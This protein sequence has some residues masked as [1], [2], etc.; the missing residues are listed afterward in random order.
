MAVSPLRKPRIN[1]DVDPE[2]RQTTDETVEPDIYVRQ[3]THTPSAPPSDSTAGLFIAAL[4][5][6][7]GFIIALYFGT[8]SDT[9]A[10]SVTQNTTQTAPESTLPAT[11]PAATTKPAEPAA[12]AQPDTTTQQPSES[13]QQGT[14]GNGNTT[15]T[16][17]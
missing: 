16:G 13:G 4:F 3:T 11:P 2:F 17:Q 14:T 12:P 10:P 8:R 9:T 6:L 15:G 5:V 1:P 7:L